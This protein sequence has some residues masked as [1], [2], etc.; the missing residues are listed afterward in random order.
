[1]QVCDASCRFPC[2]LRR[3]L[4]FLL[5]HLPSHC[6]SVD[7]GG[8]GW[9][10][11]SRGAGRFGTPAGRVVSPTW[12]RALQWRNAKGPPSIVRGHRTDEERPSMTFRMMCVVGAAMAVYPGIVPAQTAGT[13]GTGS[14]SGTAGTS[15]NSGAQ[16]TTG[17]SNGATNPLRDEEQGLT[18]KIAR[19]E[20]RAHAKTP[21]RKEDL[22]AL[23]EWSACEAAAL[24]G[25]AE[26]AQALQV[27]RTGCPDR[28]ARDGC[29]AAP[30]PER[31]CAAIRFRVPRA[32]R[33]KPFK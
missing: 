22:K 5:K 31:S 12:E 9:L 20:N 11:D 28:A 29:R 1:V 17:G 4:L 8:I 23:R 10:A 32:G 2:G 13:S 16:N 19:G 18:I 33:G 27:V 15:S 30:G 3:R 7:L 25:V 24:V 14:G 26:R 6:G 21:R